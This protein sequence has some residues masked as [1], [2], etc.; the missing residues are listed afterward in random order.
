MSADP[1]NGATRT[2]VR[3]DGGATRAGSEGRHTHDPFTPPTGGDV[4]HDRIRWGAVWT[5]V[6]TTVSL[7]VVLQLLFVA[8]G[9]LDLGVDGEGSGTTRAVVSGV[10]G[11]VAFLLGGMAAGASA[12]WHRANDGMINGVVSWAATV[13]ALLVLALIGGGALVGSLA[14]V[15]VQNADAASAAIDPAAAAQAGRE[16]AGWAALG[17]GLSVVAAALGGSLGAKLWP[18]RGDRDADRR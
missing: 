4:R 16:S 9:W 8:L 14:D 5:G 15:A 7:Y 6:L 18:G 10:L 17:L 12:L 13:V 11:L 1:G 2:D 3:T